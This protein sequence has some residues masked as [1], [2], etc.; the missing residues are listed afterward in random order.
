MGKTWLYATAVTGAVGLGTAWPAY[1]WSNVV[2]GGVS[3]VFIAAAVVSMGLDCRQVDDFYRFGDKA[4]PMRWWEW[5]L[6]SILAFVLA[7]PLY[8]YSRWLVIK[9]ERR[10]MDEIRN[11]DGGT[12]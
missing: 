1:A 6:S 3:V 8:L 2:L 7:W 10:Q 9:Y 4:F 11:L 12:A 5:V